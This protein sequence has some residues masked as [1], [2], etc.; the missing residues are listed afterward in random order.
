MIRADSVE[1]SWDV[2]KKRWNIRIHAGE[3]VIKRPAPKT[4]R[5]AQDDVL[6]A[7]AIR[8]A[9]DDGYQVDPSSVTIMH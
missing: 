1:V 8:T 5:D 9:E 2:E 3:E 4:P 7:M 6:R